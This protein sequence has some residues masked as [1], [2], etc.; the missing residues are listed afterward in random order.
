MITTVA[1]QR[2]Y[3]CVCVCVGLCICVGVFVCV[4]GDCIP[5]VINL[6]YMWYAFMHSCPQFR[7]ITTA[8][9]L[10]SP[11]LQPGYVPKRKPHYARSHKSIWGCTKKP[12]STKRLIHS[13]LY[14]TW[15]I[16]IMFMYIYLFFQCW[17]TYWVE[18]FNHQ[19]LTYLPKRI[20]FHTKTFEMRMTLAGMDWVSALLVLYTWLNNI[21][22][23]KAL[24][25]WPQVIMNTPMFADQTITPHTMCCSRKHI[26]LY[27]T[28][29]V[30]TCTFST[31]FSLNSM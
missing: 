1:I 23:M 7:V 11:C 31:T 29:G 17:D 13:I 8:A 27:R 21:T 19:L 3:L 14:A 30:S 25:W 6:S 12:S 16:H 20:H 10:E 5:C 2:L 22:R 4:L 24:N 26:V 9:F 28:S 15:T 18:S